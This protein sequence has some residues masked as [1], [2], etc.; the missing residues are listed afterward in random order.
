[1]LADFLL[2]LFH[3]G[4][5]VFRQAPESSTANSN[6]AKRV[7]EHAFAVYRLNIAG[8]IIDFD[9]DTALSA[10]EFVRLTCWFLVHRDASADEVSRRL[11]I[12]PRPSTASEHLSADLV[13]RYL[14]QLHR[15]AK[16]LAPD[17]VLTK[18]VTEALRTFPVSGV[19]SDLDEPPITPLDFAEHEGLQMLYAERFLQKPRDHWRPDGRIAEMIELVKR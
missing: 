12:P 8:P 18:R 9:F 3:T 2:D 6:E 1:M 16:L 4:E 11:M 14:P 5:I 15:R 13:L 19:L 7:L 10:A 17:D